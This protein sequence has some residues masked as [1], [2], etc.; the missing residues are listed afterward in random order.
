[1][2]YDISSWKQSFIITEFVLQVF[3]TFLLNLFLWRFFFLDWLIAC[4]TEQVYIFTFLI[5]HFLVL[6]ITLLVIS[7]DLKQ[8]FQVLSFRFLHLCQ[9]LFRFKCG[10][11]NIKW[12]MTLR[13]YFWLKALFSG[14]QLLLFISSCCDN[15]MFCLISR[16]HSLLVK[17]WRFIQE[18]FIILLINN[19]FFLSSFTFVENHF[20]FNCDIS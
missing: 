1:M 20:A 13:F 9:S 8:W 12:F 10:V 5:I 15:N 4:I 19:L 2:S 3:I 17:A 14:V 11:L 7:L 16:I 6:I 18:V